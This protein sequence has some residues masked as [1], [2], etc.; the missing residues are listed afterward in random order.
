MGV[1]MLQ[2]LESP[3]KNAL[4]ITKPNFAI[5]ARNFVFGDV[6]ENCSFV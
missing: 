4:F 5:Y 6:R 1:K 3:P 2:V